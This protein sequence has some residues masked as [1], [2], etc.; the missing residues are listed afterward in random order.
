MIRERNR[1]GG[2]RTSYYSPRRSYGGYYY[3]S[4]Y[5][6]PVRS[7]YLSSQRCSR[8]GLSGFVTAGRGGTRWGVGYR[9]GGTSFFLVR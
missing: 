4:R 2:A 1:G 9:G 3:G 7:R 8:S 6:Y 5:Y